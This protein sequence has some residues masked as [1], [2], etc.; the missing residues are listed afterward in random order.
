MLKMAAAVALSLLPADA[1]RPPGPPPT[2]FHVWGLIPG[3]GYGW[4][5]AWAGP[6]PVP[7]PVYVPFGRPPS[8]PGG[9]CP[10]P[11]R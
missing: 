3:H 2:P 10:T 4:R 6:P 8:C 11:R 7:G 9:V 5:Q 1:P